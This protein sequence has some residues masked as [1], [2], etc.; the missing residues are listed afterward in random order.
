MTTR[1][2]PVGLALLRL[3]AAAL[4]LAVLLGRPELLLVAVPLL[5]RLF[6][7]VLD[8]AR[9]R[10]S[11]THELS[12]ARFFEG[13]RLTVTVTVSAQ[14]RVRLLE[15]LEPLPP[16]LEL[17]AGRNRAVFTLE[18]GERARWVYEVRCRARGRFALGAVY[19]RVW[20]RSGLLVIEAR[21]L[22]PAS[23]S[24]YPHVTPLR[25]VPQPLRTQTSVGNYVSPTFGA[26]LEPGEI[27]PFAPGDRVKHVNW[28]ASLRVGK[29]YV[30]QHHQE[31]NADVVLMVD[32]LSQVGVPPVT[33]LDLCA[34]AAASLAQAYLARKDRVGLVEYGGV[35]SW[36]RPGSGRP[37]FERLLDALVSLQPIFTY[38]RKDLAMVPPRVLPPQALVIALTPLLDPRFVDAVGDL[39]ARGFDLVVVAVS[40]IDITR[41]MLQP[42][43]V[44]E[45]ACRIWSL[46]HR[47]RVAGLRRQGL[48]LVEWAPDEPL[49]LALAPLGRHRR[50]TARVG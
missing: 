19:A 49:E 24:V 31:R 48:M 45:V 12:A 15:L 7:G 26:G 17:V 29:L 35:I 10:Y 6:R 39:A 3:L 28:R 50:R 4:F 38:V 41:T 13:D 18:P 30:T 37:Q 47:A 46:E 20:G 9:P 2:A 21:H 1:L 23:V 40:P 11:L 42:K 43:G 16:A 33:S 14:S 22:T 34:R 36:V 44:D 32:I 27:R 25:R 8:T 5:L